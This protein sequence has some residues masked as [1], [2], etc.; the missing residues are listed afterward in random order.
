[1]TNDF[2]ILHLNYKMHFNL[3]HTHQKILSTPPVVQE[4]T[5]FVFHLSRKRENGSQYGR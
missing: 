3:Q 1:M 5:K 4:T 2:K